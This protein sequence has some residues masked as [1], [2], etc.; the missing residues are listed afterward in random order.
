MRP[1]S[2]DATSSTMPRRRLI[3]L[4]PA[5]SAETALEVAITVIRPVAGGRGESKPSPALSSG[6]RKTPPPMPSSDPSQPAEAPA[7]ATAAISRRLI[8]KAFRQ[9]PPVYHSWRDFPE[10]LSHVSALLRRRT[11]AGIV[12]RRLQPHA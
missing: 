10:I 12:P 11:R 8:Y 9:D 5:V 6:T 7:A 3:R 4:R 1:P 2:A